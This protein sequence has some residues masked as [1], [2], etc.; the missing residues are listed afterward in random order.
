[1]KDNV[2]CKRWAIAFFLWGIVN[3][4]VLLVDVIFNGVRYNIVTS[5][6]CMIA[7]FLFSYILWK[8]FRFKDD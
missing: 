7:S 8:R 6:T 4:L 5:I 2:F 1:M 3:A